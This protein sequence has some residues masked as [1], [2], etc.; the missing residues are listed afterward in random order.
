MEKYE[1]HLT[2]GEIRVEGLPAD[3]VKIISIDN[4]VPEQSRKL[5]NLAAHRTDL[6]FAKTCLDLINSASD[7]ARRALWRAAII[8]YCKC[9]GKSKR[10]QPLKAD[11]LPEGLP[12]EID[13]FYKSLRNKH[14]VHD[15]NGWLQTWAGAAVARPGKSYKVEKIICATTEGETLSPEHYG[16]MYLLV[17]HAISWVNVECDKLCNEITAE[18]EKMQR[19]SLLEQPVITY[20]APTA[21]DVHLPRQP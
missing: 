14:I 16:N 15:E 19:E 18:L 9:F 11:H 2:E 7:D 21:D 13:G 8:Y 17:E 4:L 5:R 10:R 12:R 3:T 6:A 20:R 1:I